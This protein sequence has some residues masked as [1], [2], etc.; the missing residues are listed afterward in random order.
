MSCLKNFSCLWTEIHNRSAWVKW[1]FSTLPLAA[2]MVG[3]NSTEQGKLH[4][5][6]WATLHWI[7]SLCHKS[8]THRQ[9]PQLRW[10][11]DNFWTTVFCARLQRKANHSMEWLAWVTRTMLVKHLYFRFLFWLR[12]VSAK[13]FCCVLGF[14]KLSTE[15]VLQYL[16]R[17]ALFLSTIKA[18]TPNQCFSSSTVL[19]HSSKIIHLFPCIKNAQINK[20]RKKCPCKRKREGQT[21]RHHT[22]L[23]LT[24]G[25]FINYLP[26]DGF[27]NNTV[28][29]HSKSSYSLGKECILSCSLKNSEAIFLIFIF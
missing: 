25:L 11:V 9:E 16:N 26:N 13:E 18:S 21:Y 15:S 7:T 2:C 14:L 4:P 27:S 5:S 24:T 23:G 3:V 22:R 19:S 29:F 1:R 12:S 10:C 8:E 6:L 28:K 17:A 20:T